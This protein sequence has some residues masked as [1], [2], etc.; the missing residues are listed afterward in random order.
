MFCSNL[1]LV[2]VRRINLTAHPLVVRAL[3]QKRSKLFFYISFE[4][5]LTQCSISDSVRLRRAA[6]N[7]SYSQYW[8]FQLLK[9]PFY[10]RPLKVSRST[11]KAT[12]LAVQCNFKKLICSKFDPKSTK[13]SKITTAQATPGQVTSEANIGKILMIYFYV[14]LTC[15]IISTKA[16]LNFK[17]IKQVF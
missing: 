15:Y 14:Q 8:R 13:M 9:E 12:S 11:F 17:K 6:Q 5:K 1:P 16:I 2:A 3:A 4:I 10:F 7:V